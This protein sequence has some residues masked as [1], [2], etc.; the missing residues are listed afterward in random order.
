MREYA[1]RLG[2]GELQRA[3]A[4]LL[5]IG[6]QS[7]VAYRAA[8]D[9]VTH[10]RVEAALHRLRLDHE[11]HVEE[12]EAVLAEPGHTL[13]SER[14]TARSGDGEDAGKRCAEE[15]ETGSRIVELDGVW[16]E[17]RCATGDLAVLDAVR[18]AEKEMESAYAAHTRRGHIEPVGAMLRRHRREEEAHVN[19]LYESTLWRDL[20][21]HEDVG[22]G[23]VRVEPPAWTELDGPGGAEQPLDAEPPSQSTGPGS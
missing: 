4:D 23:N 19:W 8:A 2:S 17:V 1:G 7:I 10:P 14:A 6:W 15:V 3:L 21:A 12:L 9:V 13:G 16:E 11:R 20:D 22:D 18:H 5:E